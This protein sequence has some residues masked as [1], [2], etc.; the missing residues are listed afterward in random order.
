VTVLY[1]DCFSG[2][3][4][5][6][7]LGALLDAGA[8]LEGVREHI[9]GLGIEDW[10]ISV[11]TAARGP[12]Q[13]T[14]ATVEVPKDQPPRPYRDIRALLRASELP[15]SV[16]AR[17]LKAFDV[18]AEAE[19]KIHGVA[20]EDIYLHEVGALDALVDVVGSCVALEHFAADRVVCSPLVTGRGFV[21][22]AHGALP[23]PAP[24]V[25]EI[26]AE[27]GAALTS[28][29][30]GELITPTGAALLAAIADT[31]GEMPSMTLQ[32][33][34][35]GA[36]ARDAEIP[37]V[38]R[39]LVGEEIAAAE[40]SAAI[41]IETNLDD[42]N[43]ELVPYVVESLIQA[44][45]QDA[46]VESITMKKGRPALK[47]CALTD[48]MHRWHMFEILFRETTT[49][50]VR[51]TPVAREI[52]DRESVAVEVQGLPVR[53]KIGRRHGDVVSV[54]PEYEDAAQ[55]AR[56]TGL[57]LKEVYALTLRAAEATIST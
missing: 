10:T 40:K 52:L 6:M 35:Y 31:F 19:A 16:K 20:A 14:R 3:S 1:F 56:A 43:P 44:G 9:A 27:R 13:A 45:A 8:P 50:G 28:R 26:L 33:V 11:Q 12:I 29:G 23:V 55:V 48:S 4:G 18:L 46:W 15:E 41:L 34:G 54:A 17:S 24:A 22:T 30:E 37:N 51:I 36:G 32:A 38:L 5:D 39:V 49:F 21:D 57:P 25:T 2:A 7:I 47:L 42:M 53:V